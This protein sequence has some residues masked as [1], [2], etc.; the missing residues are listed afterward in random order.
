MTAA[1]DVLGMMPCCRA[2]LGLGEGLLTPHIPSSGNDPRQSRTS[3][4]PHSLRQQTRA[5]L[6]LRNGCHLWE[7]L[8]SCPSAADAQRRAGALCRGT[9][10]MGPGDPAKGRGIN[11]TPRVTGQTGSVVL[12]PAPLSCKDKAARRG[13]RGA[14]GPGLGIEGGPGGG[15]G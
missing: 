6:R 10:P 5:W 14:P 12:T 2:G 3:G 9:C 11:Q 4:S 13:R 8:A 1:Q 15:W 7:P